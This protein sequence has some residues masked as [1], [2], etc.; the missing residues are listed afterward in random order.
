M[1]G[2]LRRTGN[3]E[4]DRDKGRTVWRLW[5]RMVINN[6]GEGPEIGPPPDP[7]KEPALQHLSLRLPASRPRRQHFPIV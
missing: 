4:A 1:T 6:Q 3:V 2:I 5:K 7:Q